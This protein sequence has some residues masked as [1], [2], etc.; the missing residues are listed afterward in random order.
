NLTTYDWLTVF[1]YIDQHPDKTQTDVVN[2]FRTRAEGALEFT[3]ATLSRRLKE[4]EEIESRAQSNPTALSSK[5][6]RVVTRPDV[7]EALVLWVRSMELKG[8]IM[9]GPMLREKRRRLE[10]RMGVPDAEQL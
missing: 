1:A 4:R 5:R 8:E 6:P 3:Q 10:E 7:E 2:F 9:N